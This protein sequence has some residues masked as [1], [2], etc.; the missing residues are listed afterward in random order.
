MAKK[1]DILPVSAVFARVEGR[2]QGVGFRYT[3][4]SEAQRLG[5]SGW[6]KNTRE[7]NVEVW[8]EGAQE[9][10]DALLKWLNRGPPGARVDS[11]FSDKRLPTGKYRGFGVEY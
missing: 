1:D 3:C 4:L 11:V 5:L 9:K 10:I 8:A 7:G 6:V 2:V